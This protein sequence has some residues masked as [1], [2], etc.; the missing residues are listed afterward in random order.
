MADAEQERIVQMDMLLQMQDLR[1]LFRQVAGNRLDVPN[2]DLYNRT[3]IVPANALQI[4]F[5]PR[6]ANRLRLLAAK[7]TVH[8]DVRTV[9]VPMTKRDFMIMLRLSLLCN[10]SPGSSAATMCHIC[11]R[12]Y[13]VF[14]DRPGADF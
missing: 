12:K 2:T 9:P 13:S 11:T 5:A 8:L 3:Y 14:K 7:H 1:E 4:P 6:L 10:G